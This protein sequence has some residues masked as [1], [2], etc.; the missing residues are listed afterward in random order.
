MENNKEKRDYQKETYMQLRVIALMMK[1]VG[2]YISFLELNQYPLEEQYRIV[3][4]IDAH[5]KEKEGKKK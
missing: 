5:I 3:N 1:K 4:E 2:R